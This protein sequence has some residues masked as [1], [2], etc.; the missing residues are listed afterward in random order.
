MARTENHSQRTV[1]KFNDFF[2]VGISSEKESLLTLKGFAHLICAYWTSIDLNTSFKD[3]DSANFFLLSKLIIVCVSQRQRQADTTVEK[4]ESCFYRCGSWG[5]NVCLY[6]RLFSPCSEMLNSDEEQGIAGVNEGER[7]KEEKERGLIW[8]LHAA[9]IS[10]TQNG[11]THCWNMHESF[12][13]GGWGVREQSSERSILF[14]K[15]HETAL[16]D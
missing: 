14:I 10:C 1:V 8:R 7:Q 2:N 16:R 6:S 3:F 15:L 5:R 9:M 12:P 11:Q 4:L 13:N